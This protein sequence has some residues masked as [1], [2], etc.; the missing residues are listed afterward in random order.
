M[1]EI[2]ASQKFVFKSLCRKYFYFVGPTFPLWM[3]GG[4]TSFV[5]FIFPANITLHVHVILIISRCVYMCVHTNTDVLTS[6]Q[7]VLRM[8]IDPSYFSVIV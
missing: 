1:Y 6:G 5:C 2:R 8:H 3:S 4:F 7:C